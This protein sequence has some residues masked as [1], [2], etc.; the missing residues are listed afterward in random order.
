MPDK[1]LTFLQACWRG[2]LAE[3]SRQL[4][5]G[6]R[7]N[8][9]GRDELAGVHIAIV[10]RNLPLL[11]LLVERGAT[12]FSAYEKSFGRAQNAVEL[13][14]E[15]GFIEGLSY[16]VD[17][18]KL[19]LEPE[20]HRNP[21]MLLFSAVENE[22]FD[23]ILMLKHLVEERKLDPTQ[24]K[25]SDGYNLLHAAEMY[26]NSIG[27]V[28]YLLDK[29]VDPNVEFID[30]DD[31]PHDFEPPDNQYDEENPLDFELD[32]T[33]IDVLEA[34]PVP[35]SDDDDEPESRSSDGDEDDDEFDED[36][37][38]YLLAQEGFPLN[39]AVGHGHRDNVVLYLRHKVDAKQK[40]FYDLTALD[41]ISKD[42]PAYIYMEEA[43]T[44]IEAILKQVIKKDV[45]P[46]DGRH[47]FLRACQRGDLAEAGKLLLEHKDDPAYVNQAN[48]WGT[49]AIHIAMKQ[50]NID[51]LR[52]VVE[53]GANPHQPGRLSDKNKAYPVQIA[54][55]NGF[56]EGIKYLV[57]EMG[58]EL[59]PDK[60]RPAE[61]LLFHANT[62]QVMKYFVEEKHLDPAK[63]VKPDGMDLLLHCEIENKPLP[64]VEYIIE[65]GVDLNEEREY[66]PVQEEG[67]PEEPD[68]DEFG[69]ELPSREMLKEYGGL[70][71][72]RVSFNAQAEFVDLY[73]R[74]DAKPLEPNSHNNSAYNAISDPKNP[75][76]EF[77]EI[78]YRQISRMLQKAIEGTY[79]VPEP[80]EPTASDAAPSAPNPKP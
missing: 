68:S 17:D 46:E 2:D 10:E 27:V 40:N 16:L 67:E 3:V 55:E 43:Y 26:G 20:P 14:V 24:A 60:N 22:H 5:A 28:E 31:E 74:H 30:D 52:L 53:C 38:E 29:H 33:V 79:G 12:T 45:I 34:D 9:I 65:N 50:R 6:A 35:V 58:F 63:A 72:V 11:K 69:N 41:A 54:A 76:K 32:Q 73:L 44:Q 21:A 59:W 8:Q 47:P 56:L 71:L 61:D 49:A 4:D 15:V 37:E 25:R 66:N 23:A 42:D 57:D 64:L 51:L 70:P 36:S 77:N 48:E 39:I 1:P 18:R 62:L 7:I 75:M 19:S 80:D 78:S 13:A